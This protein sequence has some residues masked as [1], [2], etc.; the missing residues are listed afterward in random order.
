MKK[1]NYFFLDIKV[2]IFQ[3]QVYNT[4][5]DHAYSKNANIDVGDS[6]FMNESLTRYSQ[7][8]QKLC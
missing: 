2:N 6:F 5:F 4:R 7:R 8:T 1:M 3:C